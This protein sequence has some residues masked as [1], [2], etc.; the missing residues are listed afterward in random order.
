MDAMFYE[1]ITTRYLSHK[2]IYVQ[3][4]FWNPFG[5]RKAVL[6]DFS[7][8]GFRIEF[9]ESFLIKNI[10]NIVL[11][12]PLNEFDLESNK[13]L[14]LNAEIK[15]I[16]PLNRQIGGTYRLPASKHDE[17]IEKIISTLAKSN[18]TEQK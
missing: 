14:K 17:D 8:G 7:L 5:K 11:H 13:L 9:V 2:T 16:D 4:N 12:I 3:M 15:W 1:R 6:L 18:K 10:E